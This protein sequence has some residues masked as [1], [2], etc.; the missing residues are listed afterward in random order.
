[1][2]QFLGLNSD[3]REF[4]RRHF[5]SN[6]TTRN[7]KAITSNNFLKFLIIQVLWYLH[8]DRGNDHFDFTIIFHFL[9]VI[10]Y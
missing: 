10:Q 2:K 8:L 4:T 6:K 7:H 1:M 3:D 9:F 5:I